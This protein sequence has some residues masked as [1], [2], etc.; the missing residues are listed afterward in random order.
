[1]ESRNG[2]EVK[3]DIYDEGMRTPEVFRGYRVH[4]GSPEG[5]PGIP[6]ATT[7]AL[8]GE[9]GD[10]PAPKGQVHPSHMG[11]PNWSRKGEGGKEKGNRIPPSFPLSPLSF[12]PPNRNT[13]GG[14][15]NWEAPK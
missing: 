10:R 2:R 15:P 6:P 8:M 7:W 5:V 14:R 3:L 1:M 11:W 9:E 12:P 4:I 13:K